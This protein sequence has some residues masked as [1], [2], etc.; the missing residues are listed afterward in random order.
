MFCLL[1]IVFENKIFGFLLIERL[2][3]PITNIPTKI[4]IDPIWFFF[5]DALG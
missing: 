3:D 5:F 2:R 1:L 4:Q